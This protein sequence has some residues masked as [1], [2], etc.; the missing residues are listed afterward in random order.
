MDL[1]TKTD[2]QGIII[3]ALIY[4]VIHFGSDVARIR[5]LILEVACLFIQGAFHTFP[6]Q[7]SAWTTIL[8]VL[9]GTKRLLRHEQNRG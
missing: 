1:R 7:T 2:F 8:Y 3:S 6:V 9:F 4:S 5:S